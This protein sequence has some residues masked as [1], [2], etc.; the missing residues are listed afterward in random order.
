MDGQNDGP[1]APGLM[2]YPMEAGDAKAGLVCAY[3]DEDHVTH[4]AVIEKVK[5]KSHKDKRTKYKIKYNEDDEDGDTFT[6]KPAHVGLL[7][8]W[9]RRM[10]RNAAETKWQTEENERKMQAGP[11]T[12][13]PEDGAGG[14]DPEAEVTQTDGDSP[15]TATATAS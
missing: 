8:L 2:L 5:K 15:I 14:P 3:E 6:V 9:L 11:A 10:P 4:K 1:W 13:E 12:T 7:D